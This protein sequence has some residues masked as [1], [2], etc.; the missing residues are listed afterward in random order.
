[1]GTVTFLREFAW[2]GKDDMLEREGEH[3]VNV[4]DCR[5]PAFFQRGPPPPS[6]QGLVIQTS[7]QGAG[8]ESQV[9]RRYLVPQRREGECTP[10]FVQVRLAEER[11][12]ASR[13]SLPAAAPAARAFEVTSAPPTPSQ[14]PS[15]HRAGR[16][17]RTRR[18]LPLRSCAQG[19]PGVPP[20]PPPTHGSASDLHSRPR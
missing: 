2:R 12:G 16:R 10:V 8:S 6:L 18:P 5:H 13:D 17:V 4:A 11:V 19:V 14:P 1:M 7:G 3:R 20:A 15:L 9:R